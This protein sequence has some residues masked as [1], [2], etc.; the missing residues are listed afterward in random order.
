MTYYR[1]IILRFLFVM[2]SVT[3]FPILYGCGDQTRITKRRLPGHLYLWIVSDTRDAFIADDGQEVV[4]PVDGR[5]PPYVVIV[6]IAT[7]NKLIA[8]ETLNR[9]N[10]TRRFF[11]IA[12]PAGHGTRA[13]EYFESE[14]EL[15]TAVASSNAHIRL[16]SIDALLDP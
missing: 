5:G 8:G 2:I 11:L 3:T 9:A 16:E 15:M 4:V 13:I 10:G 7:A 12:V 14:S 1:P 6:R